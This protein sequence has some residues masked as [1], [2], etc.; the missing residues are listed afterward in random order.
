MVTEKVAAAA[1]GQ[2]V[3]PVAAISGRPQK[4]V[5][6]KSLKAIRKH[7]RANKRRLVRR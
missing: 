4:V 3:A 1:E 2:V 6:N 7:V 5:A